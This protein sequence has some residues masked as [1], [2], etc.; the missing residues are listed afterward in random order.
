MLDK[1]HVSSNINNDTRDSLAF[2]VHPHKKLMLELRRAS[3]VHKAWLVAGPPKPQKFLGP[4]ARS[5]LPSPDCG[6]RG[7]RDVRESWGY[8]TPL[9]LGSLSL[10]FLQHGGSGQRK[11]GDPC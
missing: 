2:G 11:A 8:F 6:H 9:F 3:L 10:C 1:Q 4:K 5:R 7:T